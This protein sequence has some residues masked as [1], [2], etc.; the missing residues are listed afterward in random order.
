MSL[1]GFTAGPNVR[2]AEP[3]G[4]GGERLPEWMA[5]QGPEGEIDIGVRREVDAAVGATIIA[6][7]GQLGL[8]PA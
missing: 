3:M 5:G 7:A 8:V 2:D 4:N 6:R 1:D